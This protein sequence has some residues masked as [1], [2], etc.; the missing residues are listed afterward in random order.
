MFYSEFFSFAGVGDGGR[1]SQPRS[2]ANQND[3]VTEFRWEPRPSFP[4]C[5]PFHFD[6]SPMSKSGQK[7][8]SNTSARTRASRCSSCLNH[9]RRFSG[10]QTGNDKTR[11]RPG[12]YLERGGS[13][14][15]YRLIPSFYEKD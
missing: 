15:D 9:C 14:E 3:R 5:S 4:L 11:A 10:R 8:K 13:S 2:A 12:A 6:A 1:N 7:F